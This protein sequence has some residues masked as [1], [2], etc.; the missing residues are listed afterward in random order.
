MKLLIAFRFA[1]IVPVAILLLMPLCGCSMFAKE[2]RRVLNH[3]DRHVRIESRAA[4]IAAAPLTVPLGSVAFLSDAGVVNPAVQ[5]R[6]AAKDVY[7][8]YWKPRNLDPFK[9]SLLFIPMAVLT[10]PTFVGDLALRILFI[11]PHESA[12]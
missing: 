9:K 12:S 10:P 8:L 6:W 11:M 3:L 5:S 2:N 4:R 1:L 7:D